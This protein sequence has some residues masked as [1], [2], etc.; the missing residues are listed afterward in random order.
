MCET[1]ANSK[2]KLV[3]IEGLDGSGKETQTNLLRASLLESGTDIRSL[4]FPIYDSASSA[5]VRMYLAGR[6]G[7]RP[8]DVSAYAASTFYAVDRYASFKSDWQPFYEAGGL[9][10]ADRYTT[11][12]AVHQCS[13][14]PRNK[15]DEYLDWLV[16]FEHCLLEIPAPDLVIYLSI[17]AEVSQRLV[18]RRCREQGK[19]K[20]IHEADVAYMAR[21]REA[22]E[23]CARRWNWKR[24]DCAPCGKLRSVADIHE[25]ILT[26]VLKYERGSK[27]GR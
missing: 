13:K 12:N 18:E 16:D 26:L 22:A 6:F 19:S 7:E 23:Y 21:C 27:G 9:V 1:A 2:G 24:V 4:S 3:V 8:E 14:L 15:W 17:D 5:P 11:S 25:E 20:D 10:L